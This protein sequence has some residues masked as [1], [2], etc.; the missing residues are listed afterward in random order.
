MIVEQLKWM[1]DRGTRS[2]RREP[3]TVPLCPPDPTLL[4]P[5]SNPGRSGGKLGTDLLSYG[6]AW[7]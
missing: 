3:A 1:S 6:T 5:G 4:E 7:K 2:T